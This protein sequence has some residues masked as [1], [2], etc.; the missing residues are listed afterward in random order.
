MFAF[1]FLVLGFQNGLQ[2]GQP[3]DNGNGDVPAAQA[4]PFG[5]SVSA[6]PDNEVVGPVMISPGMILPEVQISVSEVKV[7][8]VYPIDIQD[9]NAIKR[10]IEEG[11]LSPEG[12]LPPS[13]NLSP[14]VP[15]VMGSP[16]PGSPQPLFT[17]IGYTGWYPPDPTMAAD[18]SNLVLSAMTGSMLSGTRFLVG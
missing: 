2:A 7:P 5:G 14:S 9:L 8:I 11:L 1:L 10:E 15:D 12:L 13:T 4:V 3:A 16:N 17:G 18:P 6:G